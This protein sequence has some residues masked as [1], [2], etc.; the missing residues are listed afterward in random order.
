MSYNYSNLKICPS[1]AGT[2]MNNDSLDHK[3]YTCNDTGYIEKCQG[4]N[5]MSMS[6][7]SNEMCE[8]YESVI[9]DML[10]EYETKKEKYAEDVGAIN[11]LKEL[12]KRLEE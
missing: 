12:L 9:L 8:Y 5:N 6:M 2:G 7:E 3:C 4:G 1:C 10:K 11:A